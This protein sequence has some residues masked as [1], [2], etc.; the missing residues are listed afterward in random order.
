VRPTTCRFPT[1]P[2]TSAC[3]S[4]LRFAFFTAADGVGNRVKES[5]FLFFLVFFRFVLFFVLLL[6]LLFPPLV[7]MVMPAVGVAVTVPAA[8][9]VSS[10]GQ[11]FEFAG[12]EGDPAAG[13]AVVDGHAPALPFRHHGLAAR[14]PNLL[15]CDEF[16]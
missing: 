9:I 12:V 4:E 13:L 11:L 8:E 2:R 10:L 14:T 5:A 1:P 6:V 3:S 15:L 16:E 7:V